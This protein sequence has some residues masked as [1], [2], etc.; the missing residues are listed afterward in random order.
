MKIAVTS[1]GPTRD[2]TVDARRGD[3]RVKREIPEVAQSN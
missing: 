3:A 1:T 2:D